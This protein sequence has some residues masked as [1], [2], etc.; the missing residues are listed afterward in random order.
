MP[1]QPQQF[2]WT[3]QDVVLNLAKNCSQIHRQIMLSIASTL[4]KLEFKMFCIRLQKVGFVKKNIP[5]IVTLKAATI[6]N[7]NS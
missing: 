3:E 2:I 1:S 4:N 5:N 6:C 7:T